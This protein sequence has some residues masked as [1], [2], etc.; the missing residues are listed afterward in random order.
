[1]GKSIEIASSTDR[2]DVAIIGIGCRFPGGANSPEAFWNLLRDGVDAITDVPT[3]RWDS[4]LFYHPDAMK[5]GK[6]NTRWGG[7]VEH[8]DHFDARFFG[9]SP[10]EAT[11]M[12]PQQRMLLEVAWEALEDGGQVPERLD[13]TDVGVFIGIATFDY[14]EIHRG[15]NDRDF[16]DAHT[17]TGISLSI[18]A[19]RISY[20]FNFK[21][22]SIAVDTA[23]SSSLTAVHLATRSLQRGECPLALVGGVN[24]ILKPESTIGYSRAS[25]LSPDGRCKAFDARANGYTRS[26]GAGIVALKPLSNALAE[27]DPIYA[28]LR[29]SAVNQDGHTHG[30]MV[31]NRLAQEAML[32]EAYRQAGFSPGQVQYIEAH[33]TGTPVGDPIEAQALGTVLSTDR[34]AGSY[35]VIGS[36][37]TNIGH[38]EAGA[39]IAGLIK[40]ALALQHREIPAN[41]HFQEPNPNIPFDE[42]RLR[43][44]TTLEPWPDGEGPARAGVNSFGFGGANAHVV[45]EEAPQS[46]VEHQD[47]GT[48]VSS[49]AYLLPLSARSPE[50]LQAFARAYQDFLADPASKASVSLHDLC[51][52][53][54]VRR[55]HHSHRLALVGHSQEELAEHLAAFVAGET[56][57]GMSSG[58]PVSGHRPRLVFVFSGMGPQWWAMGRQLLQQEPVFRESVERCDTLLRQH[59]SWS[60]LEELTADEARSRMGETEIAQP[61]NFALQVA[62][63]ALWRSWGIAPD[64]IVGHSAGE[65]AA[66]QVAGALSLEEAVR[67]I[68]HRSRLQQRTTGKGK[69]AAVGLSFEEAERVLAGYEGRLSVAAINSPRAVTLS[70]DSEALADVMQSLEQRQ[71]F[72]QLLRVEVPYHSHHMEPLKDEL[73]QSLH[74]L[75]VRPASVPLFSTVTGRLTTGQEFGADYW[76]QNIRHPVFFAAALGQ[77]IQEGYHAFLELSP[78]PVL[79]GT[80]SECLLHHGQKGTV[81]PSLR[82]HEAER[83]QLLGSLGA[84]HTLGYPVTWHSLYPAGGRCVRL[85]SYPWQR[86]RYWQESEVAEQG[87]LGRQ[88]HPLLGRR[89]V[90]A[91]PAWETR[92]DKQLL[93]YLDDHRIQGGIVYP[94][95]AYVEMALAAG[96]EVLGEGPCV[97]EEIAFQRALFLPEGDAAKLQVIFDP[98][99]ASFDIYSRTTEPEP[100]WTRHATGRLRQASSAAQRMELDKIRNRCPTDISSLCYPGLREYGLEYGPSFQGIERLWRGNGE[101]LG[102]IRL[103]ET[104]AAD[105]EDYQLH[106]VLL[107][108][109]FQVMLCTLLADARDSTTN[110]VYLPVGIDRLRV[111][112]RPGTRLWGHARLTAQNASAIEGN[113]WLLDE[114]GNVL[115]EIQGFRCQALKGVQTDA[116]ENVDDWLYAFQWQSLQ[117]EAQVGDIVSSPPVTHASWLIFADSGGVGQQ[118]AGLLTSHGQRPLLV[119]PGAAFC[120]LDAEHFQ[121]CPERLEDMREL[122]EVVGSQQ[123]ACRGVVHLWSLE[124]LPPEET[125]RASLEAAQNL[126]C[127]TVLHLVQ[128]LARVDWPNAPQLWLVTRG[129]QAVGTEGEAVAIAQA[130]LWG[131]GRVIMNEYPHLRCKMVDLSATDSPQ[132]MQHRFEELWLDNHE[133]EIAFRGD[134][135]YI[136]RLHR[137]SSKALEP[138]PQQRVKAT[139]NQPFHLE[140]SKAGVLDN[141]TLRE[142]RRRAPGPGEVEIQVYATGLNFRDVMKATGIYPTED[143]EIVQL[144]DE[145]AGRIVAL[146]EGVDDFKIGDEVIA[147]VPGCFSTFVTTSTTLVVRKPAHLSL[148]EA[149][150]IPIVFLTAYYALHHLGRLGKGERILIHAA[151]GGVGLAAVQLAQRVGAEI[152]ATAGSPEKR[153]FLRSLGVTHVMDSRS[154]D[155]ADAVLDYTDGKGVDVVLNSLAGDAIPKS[156]SVLG[157]YGRFLEIGKRDIY[158]NSKL[159]LRPFRNNLSFFAIDLGRLFQER[160]AVARD[161][162]R[163]VMRYVEDGTLRPLPHRIFPISEVASAFRYMA[164]AR[165]IGKIVLS[166]RDP[167]ALIAPAAHRAILFHADGT[168]LVAGGLGGF[169]LAVAQWMVAQGARHLV[170]VGRS[171]AASEAAEQALQAMERVGAQIVVAQA[172]VVQEQ[173]LAEVL[174]AIERSMPPLRGIIHAAGVLDDG[175][176]FQLDQERF[177]TVMAP[178]VIGAWNL[179][180]QTLTAPLDFFVLFSSVTSLVGNPG[181]GNYVA[182]NA[183]LDALAHYRRGQNLPALTINWGAIAEVG[184]LARHSEI[185][186]HLERQGLRAF[187]RTQAMAILD[188]LLQHNAV[189]VGAMDIDWQKWGRFASEAAVS[190]RFAHLLCA[191]TQ[192]HG[193]VDD[194]RQ[195]G[196]SLRDTLLAATP[197]ERQ[198][199]LQRHIGE[200]VAMVLGTSASAL[201]PRQP[202]RELGLDSLMAV[203][204]VNALGSSVGRTLPATLL[205]NYPTMGDLAVYLVREVLG[206]DSSMESEV[207]SQ[208]KDEEER[209]RVLAEIQQLSVEEMEAF[210]DEEVAT[211]MRQKGK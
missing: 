27:G 132:E 18:A 30:M 127:I 16:I 77:L 172:D 128:A 11:R 184:Y 47:D 99:V 162:L 110:G 8:I 73:L 25:M 94:G 171:G 121:L 152:F 194:Q 89:L 53:A 119:S 143:N 20:I 198:Q 38:L 13:G 155:F 203:E 125:T 134:V 65:V 33:G 95:A 202:L 201:D 39:G 159:G 60:L 111:Y 82:R 43:V 51:Y 97:L 59:A 176:L 209:A 120:R 196:T 177:K 166:L 131:L 109:C 204:L 23:C 28:I 192:E 71:V 7:F 137:V 179:H 1:M 211:L 81:L 180:A 12:D 86:E 154:L 85:P 147:I 50:A 160:P 21:G 61:A 161:L 140:I 173:Q 80:I 114:D 200:H 124:T 105:F 153:E 133:E 41:L 14:A 6:T 98:G 107:D 4:R 93:P 29:G 193:T 168:Y 175:F 113:I 76:W 156:L 42:L 44:P 126:G 142:I 67:V 187:A 138:T 169:G 117:Q 115:V 70:G 66:A 3:D 108:G 56:R 167:E 19:N 10:R 136:H 75:E 144:G 112:R 31:P 48:P 189:Q 83:Q 102:Q 123:P 104:L 210:I 170:L 63:A 183:F 188:Q 185:R 151:A 90:S 150:T 146:G 145:C 78:H 72:C 79:A 158:Q 5:A 199:V 129:A 26:E 57:P 165:H 103:P 190:P 64:A 91:H 17:N 178:K 62:L 191:D 106:P 58:H 205:F 52:T 55:S 84:L 101:A 40:T 24:A 163:D 49:R 197:K 122:L 2:L 68:F 45:L 157:A 118:L 141:L 100:S 96:K 174:A 181:Q 135:R 207:E 139:E 195:D 92:L 34:P 149:A 9:I 206:V 35:C 15:M 186:Q 46:P 37:K 69:M 88:V 74:G 148:E 208:Q 130:S 54:S 164:Q 22:P 116:S 32:R 182:A 87:R 36:V